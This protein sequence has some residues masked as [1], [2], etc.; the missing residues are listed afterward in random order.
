MR[1]NAIDKLISSCS[2]MEQKI[3]E[4]KRNLEYTRSIKL[5]DYSNPV[6]RDQA[7]ES[8]ECNEN[9]M[10]CALFEVHKLVENMVNKID[11]E[12]WRER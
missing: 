2:E 12:A 8:L 5:S 6:D 7:R 9:E 11:P 3:I 1:K 4:V 10:L